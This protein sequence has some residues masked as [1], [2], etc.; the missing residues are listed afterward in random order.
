[1][2]SVDLSEK[3]KNLAI[4]LCID[5]DFRRRHAMEP[6]TVWRMTEADFTTLLHQTQRHIEEHHLAQDRAQKK[7][8]DARE[9]LHLA[10]QHM[11]A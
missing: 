2:D 10:Q 7:L 4:Q 6:W 11:E 9:V 1:M 8:L 3:I 5:R